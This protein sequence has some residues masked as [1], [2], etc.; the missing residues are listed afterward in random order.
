MSMPGGVMMPLVTSS[1]RVAEK[2]KLDGDHISKITGKP[3][4]LVRFSRAETLWS[5][6]S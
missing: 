3:I 1:R 4:K 5:N 2:M 6:V